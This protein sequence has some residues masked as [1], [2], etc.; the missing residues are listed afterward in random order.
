MRMRIRAREKKKGRGSDYIRGGHCL[1]DQSDQACLIRHTA[2]ACHPACLPC[3]PTGP[4]TMLAS[5]TKCSQCVLAWFVVFNQVSLRC[6][7]LCPGPILRGG[8]REGL[9]VPLPFQATTVSREM[10]LSFLA[11]F[12]LHIVFATPPHLSALKFCAWRFQQIP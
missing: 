4:V 12:V 2:S 8:L 9:H 6:A 10:Q 7:C 5:S 1:P 3:H 11:P